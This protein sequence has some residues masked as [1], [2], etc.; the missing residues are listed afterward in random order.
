MTDSLRPII[1]DIW[2]SEDSLT[3]AKEIEKTLTPE[4]SKKLLRTFEMLI[5]RVN[6]KSVS[7]KITLQSN[8][9]ENPPKHWAPLLYLITIAI[10]KSD[11]LTDLPES[12]IKDRIH[13]WAQETGFSSD[14]VREA[15]IL[16]LIT[17]PGFLD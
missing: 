7:R 1:D 12:M 6:A 16:G 2:Q 8:N 13:R 15:I 17:L 5:A 4:Q 3:R 9:T 14:I 11:N 10:H